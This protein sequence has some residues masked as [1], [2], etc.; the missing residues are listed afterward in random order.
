MSNSLFQVSP[1]I[2]LF[3]FTPSPLKQVHSMIH[4]TLFNYVLLGGKVLNFPQP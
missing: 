1:S 4:N 3:L 2:C